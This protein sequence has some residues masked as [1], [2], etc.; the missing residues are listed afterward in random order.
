MSQSEAF[1]VR[2]LLAVME[3]AERPI[4]PVRSQE[5]FEGLMVKMAA[6]DQQRRRTRMLARALGFV[7]VGAGMLQLLGG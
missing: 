3:R 2:R 6:Q 7:V 4:D 1:Q 5:L